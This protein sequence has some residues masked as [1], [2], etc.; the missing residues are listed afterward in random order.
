VGKEQQLRIVQE[1]H[2]LLHAA[3]HED[4]PVEDLEHAALCV[5]QEGLGASERERG[6]YGQRCGGVVQASDDVVDDGEASCSRHRGA[7][8]AATE[9]D[10]N[11]KAGDRK[12]HEDDD[13]GGL[14][15]GEHVDVVV[16]GAG[17]E[18]RDHLVPHQHCVGE[19]FIVGIVD[20]FEVLGGSVD[21]EAALLAELVIC[22]EKPDD[23]VLWEGLPPFEP[24]VRRGA[25]CE[26]LHV[27]VRQS[28]LQG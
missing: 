16:G 1:Q 5:D 12:Q 17:A 25:R 14:L 11:L 20:Y 26:W 27:H 28:C 4:F 6:G 3:E 15:G 13:V 22:G 2:G 18:A 10:G 21:D 19:D 23:R 9:L 7:V 8:V 24:R